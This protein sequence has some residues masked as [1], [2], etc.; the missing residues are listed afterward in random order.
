MP[1]DEQTLNHLRRVREE[2]EEILEDARA[3]APPDFRM[4][5]VL[6]YCGEQDGVKD[7][8]WTDDVHHDVVQALQR[9]ADNMEDM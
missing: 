1:L 9:E 7:M 2:I 3:V 6:R 8:I 5:L 4:T